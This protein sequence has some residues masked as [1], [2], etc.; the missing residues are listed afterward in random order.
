MV[1]KRLI[2]AATFI[3]LSN[4]SGFNPVYQ[5][6]LDDLYKLQ[7]FKIITDN[8]KE[9]QKIKKNLLNLFPTQRRF[10]YIVKIETQSETSGTVSDIT[11]KIS[12]YKTEIIADVKIYSRN[13]KYDKLIYTFKE[14]KSS[15]Y[16]LVLNNIRSTLS[17]KRKAEQTSIKI[18]SEEIYK[19]IIVFLS[20]RDI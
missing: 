4:C 5:N 17:S 8:K 10:K 12:R 18:L 1:V 14:K 7:S 6:N 16:T 2:L 20:N 15:P 9:S 11:R 13:Q 19:R 3:I